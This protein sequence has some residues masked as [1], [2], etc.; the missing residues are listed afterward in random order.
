MK[1]RAAMSEFICDEEGRYVINDY[2][3]KPP[4]ASFLPGIAGLKGIP[5]WAFYVSRGQGIAGFGVR[6][7]NGPI[8]EFQPASKA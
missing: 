4:L 5:L 1:E 3:A 6:D 7:R 8:M 2:H